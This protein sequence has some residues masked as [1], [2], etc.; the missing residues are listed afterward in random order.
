MPFKN[1]KSFNDLN[2]KIKK[3]FERIDNNI[4]SG[5]YELGTGL[6][7]RADFYVPVDTNNLVNS[8]NVKVSSVGDNVTVTIGYYQSYA[9]ALHSPKKGGRMDGWKPKPVPSPGKETGGYNAD[10]KQGWLTIAWNEIGEK[11]VEDFS[12]GL[13]K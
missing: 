9:A 12:K 10:A 7:L 13:M 4:E 1:G 5:L 8:R 6:G 3:T 2:V 11:L